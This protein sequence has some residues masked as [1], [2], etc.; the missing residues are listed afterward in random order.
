MKLKCNGTGMKPIAKDI[1]YPCCPICGKEF[2]AQGKKHRYNK[3]NIWID[4]CPTHFTEI[5]DK[6][7]CKDCGEILRPQWYGFNCYCGQMY[8]N[9]FEY[10]K[11]AD[12]F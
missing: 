8:N 5:N 3:G 9:T 2:S 10:A 7:R 12:L 6:P 4:G 1:L 11:E